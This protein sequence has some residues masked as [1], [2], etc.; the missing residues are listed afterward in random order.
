MDDVDVETK[1]E[2]ETKVFTQA[3]VNALVGKTRQE[4]RG[5]FAD[6]DGLKSELQ[7]L[8]DANL[9]EGERKDRE[10]AEAQRKA[11]DAEG[12]I[13]ETLIG[14]EIRIEVARRGLIDPEAVE[15]LIDRVNLS[16]VAGQVM[17]VKEAM[18][19]L[20]EA[21][22]WL[23]GTRQAPPSLDAGGK[24]AP[25]DPALSPEQ[26]QMAHKMFGTLPR[27]E[28]EAAYKKGIKIT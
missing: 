10:L 27:A 9:S 4:T 23:K 22:P 13:A 16:E 5:Q 11:L 28:A 21:R 1:V 17:G 12:R 3:E 14:A 25:A 26:R 20:V 2:P 18:D 8:K 19:S 24:P 7:K 15:A 6:Y